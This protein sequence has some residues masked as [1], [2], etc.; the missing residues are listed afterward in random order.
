MLDRIEWQA[1]EPVLRGSDIAVRDIDARLKAGEGL[2]RV[3]EAL[4][5]GAADLIAALAAL[6]LGPE[7]AE[8]PT[9]VQG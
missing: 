1:G 2:D 4:Q 9:L 3:G 6:A 8:G 7:G 5:L